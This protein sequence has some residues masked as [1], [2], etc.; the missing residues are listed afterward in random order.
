MQGSYFA[1]AY[2]NEVEVLKAKRELLREV[3]D[4]QVTVERT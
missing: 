3:I 1:D 4:M 2:A